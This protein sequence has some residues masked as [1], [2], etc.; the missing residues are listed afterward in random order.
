MSIRPLLLS[1]ALFGFGSPVWAATKVDLDYNVRF[2]PEDDV[3]EVS[4]TLDKGEAIQRLSFNLGDEQRYSDFSSEGGEW[5]QESPERGIW[6]PGKGKTKLSYRVKISHPR[7]DGK[8]DALMTRDWALF[9]GDN[10]IPSA[11]MQIQDKTNLVA[12]LKFKLPEGWPSVETGWPRVGKN[13]F[14]IN[15]PQRKFDRP[16]GWI[17]AGKIGTRRTK[18]GETDVTI[19]APDGQ[20]MRRMD[21]LT[22]LTYVWPEAQAVFPRDP[23][24]LLVVGANDP[25]WRGGLSASNSYFMHAGRPTVSENGTSSLVHELVH[26]FTRIKDTDKSDWISEGLAEYYAIELV[27]RSGGMTEE[28]YQKVREQLLKW[29]KSVKTLRTENSTGPIT[30]R[31]VLMLQDLDREIRK[32]TNDRKQLSLDDVTRGL[33]RLDKVSTKDFIQISENVMGKSSDVLDTKL[34]KSK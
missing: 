12:H 20:G 31:A 18:L 30:A 34:L 27:R 23:K 10:L 9:R 21:M 26:V 24:K 6:T 8:F 1:V 16:T 17:L 22:M 13:T 14:R 11:A 2:V 32:A 19:A 29:S 28:R 25:M 5:T 15:N 7:A 3:A 33:M 4:M